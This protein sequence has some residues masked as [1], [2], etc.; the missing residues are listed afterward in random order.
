MS[1]VLMRHEGKYSSVQGVTEPDHTIKTLTELVDIL[2]ENY[3]I[4][5]PA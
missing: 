1:T 2:R 5:I 3:E 4:D